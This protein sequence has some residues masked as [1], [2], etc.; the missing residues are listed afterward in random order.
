MTKEADDFFND[1]KSPILLP[2]TKRLVFTKP[3]SNV[4]WS[5]L[6]LSCIM[7][8]GSYYCFDIPSALKTQIG[9]YMGDPADEY[10]T[11]FALMYT[12]YAVPNAILPFFGGYFVDT[13][14]VC[15]SL[16]VCTIFLAAGQTIVALGF[17]VKSWYLILTGRFVFALGGENL[18]VASSALLADWFM[19][20]ELAFSFG[21]N[22][23]IAR[24]GSVINNVASPLLTKDINI[25]FAMW[26]GAFVCGVSVISVLMTM[27][28]D[29]A[30]DA[31]I[32]QYSV[33]RYSTSSTVSK[34]NNKSQSDTHTDKQ[35]AL[36]Q[37]SA[38][39]LQSADADGMANGAYGSLGGGGECDEQEEKELTMFQ[40]MI[41]DSKA[42]PHLFWV[43]I[44]ITLLMYGAVLP[45]N[46][47]ASS[48][49]LERNYFLPTPAD[50]PLHYG[51]QCQ[52]AMN[53]VRTHVNMSQR[54]GFLSLYRSNLS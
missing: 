35:L 30:M 40:E 10:E 14:G 32:A 5:V 17:T 1:L 11:Y 12:V 4:R 47:V 16:L 36:S 15:V 43:L 50:C 22:L 8:L 23:S 2:Q 26:M 27:P 13:F 31:K 9:V 21:V 54:Y 20:K 6:I 24:V 46:N 48:L 25:L 19:G 7:L 52:S 3:G 51:G 18:I 49:L 45:F 44:A 41:R 37:D 28:I 42:L 38:A 33:E 34:S 53:Q 39:L 29:A